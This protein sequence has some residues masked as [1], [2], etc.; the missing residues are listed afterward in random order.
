MKNALGEQDLRIHAE[1]ISTG[2]PRA[3]LKPYLADTGMSEAVSPCPTGWSRAPGGT[4]KDISAEGEERIHCTQ[5][6]LRM[7]SS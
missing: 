6:G 5:E 7:S 2:E 1:P 4:S 3:T